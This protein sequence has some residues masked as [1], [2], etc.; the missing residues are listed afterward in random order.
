[1]PP[2]GV[3]EAPI[4]TESELQARNLWAGGRL[5][6]A[7]M[8]FVFISFVFAFYYLRQLNV[9]GKWRPHGVN[10]PA[11]Y[12]FAILACMLASALVYRLGT[13]RVDAAGPSRRWLW[14]SIASLALGIG[15]LLAIGFEIP[16]AGFRPF[17]GAYASVFF[18]WTGFFALGV[19]GGVYYL[20][21]L[22]ARTVR[23]RTE[24]EPVVLAAELDAF[25][26]YW[27][28]MALMTVLTVVLL[29]MVA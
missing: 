19:F 8:A 28:F 13:W 3:V 15:A 12:G 29:Y 23:Y 10:P 7:A 18:A 20:E 5:T 16:N 26:I 9:E 4:P 22:V 2:D 27:Y 17:A 21:T 14:P 24:A 6:A 1:M 25:G 11:T